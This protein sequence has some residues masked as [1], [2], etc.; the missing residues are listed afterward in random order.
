VR[1]VPGIDRELAHSLALAAGAGDQVHALQGAAGLGDARRELAQ[2][3]L[4]GVE[5]DPHGD[6]ELSA[7]RHGCGG[8]RIEVALGL[9][10]GPR[11]RR[12]REE[13]MSNRSR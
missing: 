10:S 13:A 3:L 2:G 7:D 9:P 4:A 8:G 1:G 12:M 5:L 11:E 6:T